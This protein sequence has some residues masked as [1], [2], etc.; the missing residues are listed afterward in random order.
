MA[1]GDWVKP[2]TDVKLGVKGSAVL[3]GERVSLL[4]YIFRKPLMTVRD[5][6]GI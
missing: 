1:E 5:F 4:Y 3:Y 2:V 6:L